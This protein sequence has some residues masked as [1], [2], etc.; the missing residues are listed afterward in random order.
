ML[1]PSVELVY[2]LD[3]VATYSPTAAV[4]YSVARY[5]LAASERMKCA[6]EAVAVHEQWMA[7]KYMH[8]EQLMRLRHQHILYVS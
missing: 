8:V 7:I 4:Q 6:H 1:P 3:T 2:R 5:V